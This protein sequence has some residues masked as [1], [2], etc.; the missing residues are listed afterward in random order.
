MS[1]A[2]N[3]RRLFFGCFVALVAT[4]FGFAVRNSP[5]VV[6]S[7]RESFDLTEE[8]VGT[9]IGVGLF[10]FAISI[11]LLSLVV[12]RI[13]YG[14]TLVFAFLGH[15]ISV[16]LTITADDFQTLYV[17]TFIYALANGAVEAV[18]NPVVATIHRENK[19]HWLNILHAG[20]PGGLVLGGILSITVLTLGSSL[21]ASLPGELWQWQLGILL[22]PILAYGVLLAGME[23]PQQERVEAGVS[24]RTMLEEFGAGSAFIVS[25]LIIMGVSQL[26]TVFGYEPVTPARALLYALAPAAIFAIFV[27]SFGRPMFVFLMLVMFLLATTE[28]GTD[29]WIQSIM[30]AVLEDPIKGTLFLTYTS[31]IMFVLRFFAGP[32]VHRISPLGLLAA[33]SALASLGLYW[34]GN[35]GTATLTLFAA[36]TLYGVGK[37][38]FWPTT[39]GVVS[40]QYPKGGAL[41]LNAISG[42]GM[43]SIGT[44]GGPAI[45]TLQDETINAAVR[46]AI[47]DAHATIVK[48]QKG[49]F[50][51]YQAID[52]A[53]VGELPPATQAQINTIAAETKQH[54]LARIA[55]L[56]AIMCVC[57]VALILYFKSRGGYKA[58]V[59]TGH[60]AEDEKF[61]GGTVG[62]GEG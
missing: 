53:K 24:Y 43:I 8:Q 22:L 26:I 23:F 34:L 54:A 11:I 41:L 25:F 57:Y 37:T 1:Q 61:T 18:I 62:P 20:W 13:G 32:I 14:R 16:L 48:D 5:Q 35:A 29:G 58:E 15:L 19:T 30:A 47:P 3:Q 59:L 17:A 42:V 6:D 21:G 2:S 36:A 38:F 55:V 45:G 46:E 31:A 7:W 9:L 52:G 33:C 10:P 27:Q 39:L 28:L 50:F 49:L 44:L 51:D 12:D 4:A 60:A 40:E 56:P